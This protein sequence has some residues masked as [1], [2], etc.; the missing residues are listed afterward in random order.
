MDKFTKAMIPMIVVLAVGCAALGMNTLAAGKSAAADAYETAKDQTA[1]SVY[2]EFYQN[3]YDTAEAK[4]HVSND[5]TIS[6]D[7]LKEESKL[8]VL[9]VNDVEYMIQ[10]EEDETIWSWITDI[11]T[12]D[13]TTWIEVPGNGVFTVNL[14]TG[15]FIID[16]QRKYVLIRVPNPEL[17]EFSIDYENVK[18]LEFD[19]TGHHSV[20][21]GEELVREQLQDASTTLRQR[22]AANQRF[23][24]SA[25]DSAVSILTSRI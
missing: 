20:K 19:E 23:Y 22:I 2:Q 17:S 5:I 1:D 12:G 15:E 9:K 4:H 6:I 7:S 3:S 25:R 14:Q 10:D 18:L 8:E 21:D 16:N 11:F 13:I 24:Q